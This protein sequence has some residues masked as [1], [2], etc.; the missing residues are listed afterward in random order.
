MFSEIVNSI[1]DFGK[2]KLAPSKVCDGVGVF[3]ITEILRNFIL[4][5]D[6]S[7]DTT[8]IPFTKIH[9]DAVK[10]HLAS[11]CISDSVGIYLSRTYNNI[12][13]SYYINHSDTPNVYHDLK[14]DKYVTIRSILPGE[15]L[16][17]TYTKEEIDWLT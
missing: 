4:F 2:T 3:A 7:A 12:N 13:M 14:Q 9:D 15:E 11:I 10:K 17:C 16:T 5:Q 8:H 1:N 6:V